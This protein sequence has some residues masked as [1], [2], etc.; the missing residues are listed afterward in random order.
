MHA[1][2]SFLGEKRVDLFG[3][4]TRRPLRFRITKHAETRDRTGDLQ[5]FSLTLSQLSYRGNW[6]NGC[7]NKST[8][9]VLKFM[10]QNPQVNFCSR[11]SV[12][13]WSHAADSRAHVVAAWLW[14]KQGPAPGRGVCT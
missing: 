8:T 11:L 6:L 13:G 12:L 5:I 14:L 1:L 9:T 7:E 2:V 4:P 10:A 3:R